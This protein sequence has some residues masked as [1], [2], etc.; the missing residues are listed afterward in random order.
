[1]AATKS[2]RSPK[3]W[4]CFVAQC[5]HTSPCMQVTLQY[6][7]DGWI[8]AATATG[9]SGLIPEAY[10]RILSSATPFSSDPFRASSAA[11]V[12]AA[13]PSPQDDPF[14]GGDPFS[15]AGGCCLFVG[16]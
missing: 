5:I 14:S 13:P 10:L 4:T 1:M 11:A 2:A 16:C 8:M 12:A 7:S 6:E 15:G 9:R 3:P